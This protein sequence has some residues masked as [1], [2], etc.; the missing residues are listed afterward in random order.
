MSILL[1]RMEKYKC[2]I[3]E[4]EP[5]ALERTSGYVAKLPFLKLEQT[6]DS[7]IGT[8][9]VALAAEGGGV[10]HRKPV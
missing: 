5:L 4:D 3:V 2:V 1:C 6:F 9:Y 8:N 7:A 10:S